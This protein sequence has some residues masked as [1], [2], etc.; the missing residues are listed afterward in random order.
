MG[1]QTDLSVNYRPNAKQYSALPRAHICRCFVCR[2]GRYFNSL[3]ASQRE[4][5][6]D[7]ESRKETR[8][9]LKKM[10]QYSG[11]NVKKKIWEY[12]KIL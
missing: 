2:L 6:I 4:T 11:V 5:D 7:T 8:D 9:V 12:E 1:F 10:I 3:Q